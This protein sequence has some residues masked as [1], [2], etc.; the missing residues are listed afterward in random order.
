MCC[1]SPQRVSVLPLSFLLCAVPV[2]GHRE[3]QPAASLSPASVLPAVCCASHRP[4]RVTASSESQSCLCP[5]CCVL[6]QSQA[7]VSHS[8]QR[9]SVLPLLHLK[10]SSLLQRSTV[11]SPLKW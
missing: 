11:S 4:Q 10:A 9:V 2:T 1:V 3:S 5:S 8:Q 6:C 7:T